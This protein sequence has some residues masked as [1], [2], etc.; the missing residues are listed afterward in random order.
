MRDRLRRH[1][2]LWRLALALVA[3]GAA[4]GAFVLFAF[5]SCHDAG[6][7][8]AGEFGSTH[9]ESYASAAVLAGIA[10]PAA[11]ATVRR[12]AVVL[13][14]AA[15]AGAGVVALLAWLYES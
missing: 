9:V 8:C 13:V 5:G 6:G 11:V 1:P 14:T 3:A 7:F 12:G 15:L 2:V 4:F 10:L